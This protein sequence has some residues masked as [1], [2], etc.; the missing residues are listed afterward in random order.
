MPRILIAD[1]H[2][3]VR[4]YVREVLEDE[5]G[6][7]VCGEAGTGREAIEMT[8]ALTPD[9]VVLDLS[10]PGVNGLDAARE[11]HR[12]F[13]ATDILIL[14]MHDAPELTRE[15][16]ASGARACLLKTDL[17]PLVALIRDILQHRLARE[18]S[19]HIMPRDA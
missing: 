19:G 10:M 8:E 5:P 16:L 6:W 14:T 3:E 1:D 15:A 18:P 7:Q 17:R 12:R 9:I 2:N 11:I 4:G 13:P